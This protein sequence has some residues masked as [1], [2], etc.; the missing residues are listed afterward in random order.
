MYQVHRTPSSSGSHLSPSNRKVGRAPAVHGGNTKQYCSPAVC[1]A[2]T[3]LGFQ[4]VVQCLVRLECCDLP[5]HG[6]K[7]GSYETKADLKVPTVK[8]HTH[9]S[10]HTRRDYSDGGGNARRRDLR[11]SPPP[12]R[13][14]VCSL[15]TTAFQPKA[16]VSACDSAHRGSVHRGG[17]RRQGGRCWN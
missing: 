11:C 1:H 13:L 5:V 14:C 12:S 15:R 3:K 9:Q 2:A 4:S 8:A 10:N 6:S 17:V 16:A 7:T